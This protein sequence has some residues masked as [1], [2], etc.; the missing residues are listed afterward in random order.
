MPV[1]RILPGIIATAALGVAATP[2]L[3]GCPTGADMVDGIVLA[4]NEPF[5]RRADF[6]ATGDGFE[7]FRISD[8]A[9]RRQQTTATYRHGLVM[10]RE[11]TAAGT[12]EIDYLEDPLPVDTLPETGQI[13]LSGLARAPGGDTGVTLELAFDG[14]NT[15]ALAECVFATWTVTSTLRDG[16]E[17]GTTFRVEYAPELDLVLAASQIGPDGT[18]TPAFAYQWAGTAADVAR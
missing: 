5:F 6:K 2:G 15:V 1:D 8:A 9:G 14:H 17:S 4:Q 12:V 16:A 10:T 7:E 3:A 13:A 11:Q 18:S